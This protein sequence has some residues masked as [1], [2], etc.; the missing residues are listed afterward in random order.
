MPFVAH[1]ERHG[2]TSAPGLGNGARVGIGGRRIAPN[3]YLE[4][5]FDF[6]VRPKFR[7]KSYRDYKALLSRHIRLSLGEQMI[8]RL[9]PL[10]LQRV[11]YE[12]Y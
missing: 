5:C 1:F 9:A 10:D 7:A 11:F 8:G 3:Q 2:A 12:I 6:A 4:L